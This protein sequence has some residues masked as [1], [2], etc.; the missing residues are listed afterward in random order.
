MRSRLLALL[1]CLAL[2]GLTLPGVAAASDLSRYNAA[3]EAAY[4]HYRSA[5][6]YLH[7]GNPAVADLELQDA[8]DAWRSGVLPFLTSPPDA[9]ADDGEFDDALQE[10]AVRLQKA[11]ALA[12]N[13][14]IEPAAEQLQPIRPR[15]AALRKRNGQRVFADCVEDANAAM[16]RLWEFRDA[17]LDF[18]DRDQ[19]NALR[20]AVSVTH[21]LYK[22]CQDEA[23]AETAKAPEFQRIVGG[24]VASLATLPEA[25]DQADAQRVVNLLRELRSYDR[26]FW[27]TFG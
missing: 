7:N 23:P 9:Y 15:L 2:A 1:I 14:E 16:D 5:V 25:I 27:L 21:F 13:A 18:G 3:V 12:A 8:V 26:L 24:A 22:R 4:G 11:E 6:F 20:Y 17:R 19:M 10:V